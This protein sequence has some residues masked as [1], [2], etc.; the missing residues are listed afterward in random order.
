[1]SSRLV[2][3]PPRDTA[4]P[5][6]TPASALRCRRLARAGS[7]T[8]RAAGEF[9]GGPPELLAAAWQPYLELGFRH[10]VVDFAAPHDRETL[11]RLPAV[12]DL[13]A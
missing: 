4:A 12:R 7:V 2:L 9:L 3:P 8:E 5:A 1:M 6:T 13:L 11:E 10:I